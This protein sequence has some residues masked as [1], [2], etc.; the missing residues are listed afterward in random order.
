MKK[1]IGDKAFYKLMFA[2]AVPLMLQNGI[3]SLVAMLDNIMVGRVGTEQMTGVAIANQLLFIYQL[4]IF[5]ALSGAGIYTSQFH[6]LGDEKGIR[7]SFR[8]KLILCIA[9]AATATPLLL[10]LDTEL[11]GLYL[12]SANAEG[13]PALTLFYAEQ[14]MRIMLVGFIPFALAQ[15]YA[16]TLREMKET[17]LPM[18][19]GLVAVAVNMVLNYLLIFGKM[20]LPEMGVNG[21]AVATVISRF[22]ELAVV[23]IWTHMH[24]AKFSFIKKAYRSL[25]VPHGLAGKMMK[26]AAP[27]L[28]NEGIW[29]VGM[30]AL[31][32]C[33][34]LKGIY[35]I[36]GY[37]IANTLMQVSMLCCFAMGNAITILVGNQLGA[38]EIEKAKDTDRKLIAFSVASGLVIGALFAAIAPFFPRLYNTEDEVKRIAEYIIIIN[39]AML[40]VFS[41]NH[42]SYFTLR[43]GGKT[44]ITFLFDGAFTICV[45]LPLAFALARFTS[46][47]MVTLYAVCSAAEILK[48]CIGFAFLRSGKWANTIVSRQTA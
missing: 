23:G 9:I 5:G 27:L 25:R 12:R 28:I 33:Y 45:N 37:N 4:L 15:A 1:L 24:S 34:S 2:V 31:A 19:A 10:C 32:Q 7:Y 16:T 39:A 36:A 41:F 47:D 18:K 21:A 6:G 35:A 48:A 3:T 11:I 13:D 22:A 40:P 26:T 29:S 42:S 38:G 8:F 43:C 44:L 46:M 14:Y 17:V 30:A 20:G